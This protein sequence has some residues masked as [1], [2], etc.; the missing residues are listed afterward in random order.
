[1]K[2]PQKFDRH[3]LVLVGHL[4]IEVFGIKTLPEDPIVLVDQ[5]I[6]RPETFHSHRTVPIVRDVAVSVAVTGNQKRPG[7]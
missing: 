2:A 5:E 6:L 1:M 7:A 3:G 4:D